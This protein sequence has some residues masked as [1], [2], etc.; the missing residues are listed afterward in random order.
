[1]RDGWRTAT[2]PTGEHGRWQVGDRADT[3]SVTGRAIKTALKAQP[4]IVRFLSG[5]FGRYPWRQSGAIVDDL[6][7]GFALETQTR[8]VY[9]FTYA[10][11]DAME[12]VIA[13][14]LAHQWFGDRLRLRRW[15]D[16]WLNEGFATYAEW[17]WNAHHTNTT[18]A[19][20][21]ASGEVSMSGW[22]HVPV[23]DLGQQNLFAS[24]VAYE[25]GAMTLHRL[26]QR[27]GDR[28]FWLIMQSWVRQQR[29]GTVTTKEFTTLAERI[30]GDDLDH[31]FDVW[32]RQPKKPAS[33]R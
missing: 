13:H 2:P 14:E 25:R 7:T 5:R 3:V 18:M 27:V 19:S 26:R 1:M 22:W 29:G 24:P 20:Q 30:S 33:L 4:A 32:L 17:L 6:D 28:D 31:F 10:D 15:S 8:P 16:L 11:A 12:G 21:F 9:G 23:T